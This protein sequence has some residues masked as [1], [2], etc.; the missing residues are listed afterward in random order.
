MAVFFFHT[1]KL[2]AGYLGVPAFFVL[3]GFLLTPILIDMKAKFDG[4]AFFARFYGRRA[5]RIFPLYYFYLAITAVICVV[6]LRWDDF[7]DRYHAVRFLDQLPMAAL[8]LIDIIHAGE[9]YQT[10]KLLSHFWSLAVEE[11]F[12]L[13]WPL[14]IF[15]VP[16]IRIKTLLIVIIC[17]GPLIR[18]FIGSD[19]LAEAMLF[20]GDDRDTVV[21]TLPF[22]HLDG[23][24]MGGYFALYRKSGSGLSVWIL[25]ALAYVLGVGSTWM[26][27][28]PFVA[29]ELGYG[30]FMPD[31]AKHIWGYS[32]LSLVFANMLI[33]I[34]DRKFF[35]RLFE[36]PILDYLGKISYGLYVYHYAIILVVYGF[37]RDLPE[38]VRLV[39][40]LALSI[41]V[42]VASYELF[43]KKFLTFKDRFFS[44]DPESTEGAKEPI[45]QEATS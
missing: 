10:T 42:S 38:P 27:G 33:H 1:Y 22:S 39:V 9:G 2:H 41:A 21:Y 5:L 4:K 11:Q 30:P 40:S 19:F 44:R 15:L 3:S 28:G 8:F 14:V 20:L 36:N 45:P 31:A 13:V 23:F 32:L 29:T 26:T 43:E 34:R 16:K 7:P 18:W 37:L 17:C 25:F 35:P 6:A 12:Y 24:A